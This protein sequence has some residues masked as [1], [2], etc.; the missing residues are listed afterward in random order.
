[1]SLDPQ[2][3]QQAVER[4]DA[5]G[6][7][8]LL[9][10]ATETDRRACAKAL[11]PMLDG[12]AFVEPPLIWFMSPDQLKKFLI[13]QG[14]DYDHWH[15]EQATRA[16]DHQKWHAEQAAR[17][18]ERDDWREMSS[19]A[20]FLAAAL[21][22]AGG[23]K[24]A[25]RAADDY[26]SPSYQPLPEADV[27]AVCGVLADRGPEWLAEFVDRRLTEVYSF[28]FDCWMAARRLVR[29]GAID[30]PEVPQYTTSLPLQMWHIDSG[31]TGSGRL[32]MTVADALL[33]DPGLLDEEVW[34]LFTVPDAGR[35]LQRLDSDPYIGGGE[36][37]IAGGWADS[38]A[39]L[40]ERGHLDRGRL[41]DATLDAF[42]RDFAPNR[43]A[44]YAAFHDRLNPSLHEKAARAGRYLGLLAVNSKP[45]VSLG[46]RGCGTLL[47]AG[48]LAPEEFLA[49]SEP[50]L[51]FPQKSTATAQLKLIGKVAARS[52]DLRAL[53]MTTAACAFGHQREDVQEAAL[54]L[55]ARYGV[56]EGPERAVISELARGLSPSLA[57]DAA[58][59]G[60]GLAAGSAAG[61]LGAATDTQSVA[62]AGPNAAPDEAPAAPPVAPALAL[63]ELERRIGA[64]SAAPASGLRPA[65]AAARRGEVAG[66]AGAEP[67]AGRA[68]PPPLED[69]EELVQ[70]LTQ[71]MEDASDALAAERAL[72]GAVRLAALPAGDRARLAAPLLKRA[73]KRAR[74]DWDGPFSGRRATADMACLALAWGSGW[75]VRID[76][77]SRPYRSMFGGEP[78]DAVLRTGAASQMAGILSARVWEATAL[79]NSG[80][81]VR[82]LAEPESERGALSPGRLLDRLGYWTGFPAARLPRHDLEVALLRLAPGADDSFWSAWARVHP[83]S[84]RAARHAYAAGLVPLTFEPVVG[85]PAA[86]RW[87]GDRR[88]HTHVL[89]RIT[90]LPVDPAGHTTHC[91]RLL[92]A[93]TSPLSY[94]GHGNCDRRM[95]PHYDPV[96]A[97]WPMLCPWR[98]ELGAAHLLSPLSEGL[99]PGSSQATAAVGCLASSGHALGEIG[100]LA[101]AAGLASAEP[102][103]R[104]AA[105]DAWSQAAL[106][107]RLDP[108]LAASAISAG[109]TGGAFKLNRI[110]DGLQHA[111]QE[112]IAGYRI[113]E[114]AF[115]AADAL[116]PARP[117]NLHL[118]LELAARIG[119]TTG[120]PEPPAVITGLAAGKASS[121]L[122]G[123]ARRLAHVSNGPAPARGQASTQAL[124]ALAARA[125][126]GWLQAPPG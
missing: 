102:D 35:E 25:V 125:E 109:V 124:A 8:Q 34:R 23:V 14:M 112:P 123:A 36:R 121:R 21:G 47:D 17:E 37:P 5:P 101:L 117:A 97:A 103:T 106:D 13:S 78:R 81:P 89:A 114:T 32:A 7:R 6:V 84:A 85:E 115:A 71:L 69:P 50:A 107:G 16:M 28:G 77:A 27:D 24:V 39:V 99:T 74:E 20:A 40:S 44:W 70:L 80:R 67:S 59:L 63:D 9:R 122:T 56:A 45:G 87:G 110:A 30:R 75:S 94:H 42:T 22:L 11:K 48:R 51:L 2:L 104:I 111:A 92:T 95:D 49:A 33:A 60:L 18:R 68:L 15:A 46:Q 83:T 52:P 19:G 64:T 3:V 62:P 90:G 118:L 55:I 119:A 100:H 108:R 86:D 1:M 76:R 26:E 66:P 113:I 41:I 93:L 57:G 58:A 91:W 96:V 126:P 72:A 29:L 105:A 43:V 88:A 116:I 120:T 38:L 12:P 4:N 10:H 82:L 54:V 53:A 61:T 31:P 73:D 98:P 79:I 65:L